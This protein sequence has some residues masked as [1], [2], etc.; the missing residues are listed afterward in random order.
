MDFSMITKEY[1]R[2]HEFVWDGVSHQDMSKDV[3]YRLYK[4][5][6]LMTAI[7]QNS[8]TLRKKF[9]DIFYTH[10]GGSFARL[11]SRTGI[12][13]FTMRKYIK[14]NLKQKG[15]NIS[16]L[17]IA[18]IA[19]GIPLSIEEAE[20]LFRLEGHSLEPKY[21]RL[22][23]IVVDALKSGDNIEDFYET[24]AEFEIKV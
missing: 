12:N 23:A 18:K 24:C 7:E 21:A 10:F 14:G 6:P 19:I 20:E 4:G 17:A 13:E 15:R 8:T 9:I 11:E 1:I 16:R 22:D 2:T 3:S 5:D